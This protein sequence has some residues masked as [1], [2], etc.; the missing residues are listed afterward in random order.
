VLVEVEP[1]AHPDFCVISAVPLPELLLSELDGL[2]RFPKQ[3][4][5][6]PQCSI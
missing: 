4:S 6:F 1:E 5:Q 3:A 2:L